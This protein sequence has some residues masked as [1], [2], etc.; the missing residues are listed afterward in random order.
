[1][2]A[3]FCWFERTAALPSRVVGVGAAAGFAVARLRASAEPSPFLSPAIPDGAVAAGGGGAKLVSACETA[4]T[5]GCRVNAMAFVLQEGAERL[6]GVRGSWRA[7]S[8]DNPLARE[9]LVRMLI[10][11]ALVRYPTDP[12]RDRSDALDSP[13]RSSGRS[14][15]KKGCHH[16]LLESSGMRS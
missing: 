10:S 1:M 13:Q 15:W 7:R 5:V 4:R 6:P 2:S 9:Y 12:A 14:G 8:F 16:E 3:A 11:P